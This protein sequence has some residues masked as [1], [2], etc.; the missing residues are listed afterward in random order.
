MGRLSSFEDRD[1][2]AAVGRLMAE[3]GQATVTALR[4]ATG[5]SIGSLYH[6]FRSREGVMAEAWLYAVRTFHMRIMAAFA[7]DDVVQAGV[8]AAL[9]TPRFCRDE[10]DIALVLVCCRPSE[11]LNDQ[12]PLSLREQLAHVNDEVGKAM[13]DFALRINRPLLTC[14][15]ATIAYPLGAVRLFL[16]NTRVPKSIDIELEQSVR[17]LLS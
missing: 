4:E 10:P 14:R 6:R 9:A 8:Q 12:T 17:D 3:Q 2:Y 11:F 15:L 1:V 16:P 5:I 7:I 13:V